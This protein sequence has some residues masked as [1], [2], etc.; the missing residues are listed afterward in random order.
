[1]TV[2]STA[3]TF[4]GATEPPVATLSPEEL[5]AAALAPDEIAVIDVREGGR[6]E[7]GHVSI[8]VP[9]P[10]SEI[11]LKVEA[12]LP[13]RSVRL[14]VTDDD[15]GAIGER[16]ARRL[17]ALG[18][19][20]VRLLAGGLAGWQAAGFEAITGQYSLSKALGEFVERRYHTPRI[21]ATELRERIET[22]GVVVLDTRPIEE[23]HHISIPGGVAA[24]GVELLYRIF[25]AVPSPETPVVINCAG[26]TR[27]IIGAQ[28][29]QNAGFPNPV[30]SL[31]NGTAAWLLAGLEP[32]RGAEARLPPPSP[33]GL[34]RAKEAAGR[35]AARFGVR[36]L[37]AEGLAA[38]RGES[39]THTLYLFDI[40]TPE[41]YAA[42]HLP[43]TV[44]APGGQLV[45][46]TDSFVGSRNGRIVLVDD[47]DGV[48]ATLT[49]SWLIQ[50]GLEHVFV[51]AVP[52]AEQTERGV[53]PPAI[54][55]GAPV[56]ARVSPAQAETLI[57][58]GA[59]VLD[60]EPAPPYYRERRHLPGSR[61][62]RRSTL[63]DSLAALPGTGPIVL[64]SADGRLAALAASELEKHTARR[65]VALDGGTG[66][67]IDAG[68]PYRT[69][70]DQ[71]AL[72]PE[73]ALPKAPTLEERRVTLE[74]YVRW[75]D[76]ITQQLERDGLVRF[77]AFD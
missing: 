69:G 35:V 10:L 72:R 9:L 60:L 4:A 49:A 30:V 17:A 6:F 3:A 55:G 27:A 57:G 43:G 53:A 23:F 51:H 33:E 67:W 16:A 11:E 25:D 38:L 76:T 40:R 1:M 5:H 58:E 66:G 59:V 42:G 24:P 47:E 65:V 15:G 31:E 36:R 34:E 46:T 8:A 77:R 14:V 29:L 70:L 22:G 71:P 56:V 63:A 41:E 75:G 44:S 54:A 13:R 20:D 26:R 2:H 21:S 68:R 12:L 74:A 45:Q 48:R 52:A 28:A 32:A 19:T 61:V 50:L 62:A 7:A 37:D 73:E 18:Y 64:T 39:G